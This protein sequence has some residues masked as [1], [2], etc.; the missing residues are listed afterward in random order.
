MELSPRMELRGTK[1][2]QATPPS[3]PLPLPLPLAP[4]MGCGCAGSLAAPNR[5]GAVAGSLEQVNPRPQVLLLVLLLLLPS[6]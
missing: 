5:H 1:E 2:T 6:L 4:R 3:L